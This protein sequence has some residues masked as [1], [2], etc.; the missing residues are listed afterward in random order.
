MYESRF[1]CVA[2]AAYFYPLWAE[3]CLLHGISE[4]ELFRL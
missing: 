3:G 2:I 1:L 4:I